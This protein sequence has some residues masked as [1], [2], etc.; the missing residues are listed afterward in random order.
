M[1]TEA[2]PAA[3]RPDPKGAPADLGILEDEMLTG[4]LSRL[5]AIIRRHPTPLRETGEDTRPSARRRTRS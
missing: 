5:E 3:R 4:L 2:L 1:P